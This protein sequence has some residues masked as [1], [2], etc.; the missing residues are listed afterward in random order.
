M[1]NAVANEGA[2]PLSR[3]GWSKDHTTWA[4]ALAGDI[5]HLRGRIARSNRGY[6]VVFTEDGPLVAASSSVRTGTDLNP[7]T[8]DFVLVSHPDDEPCLFAIAPRTAEL[9]RR[10]P[11]RQPLP[12]VLAANVDDVFVMHGLDR[13][14]NLRRLERQLV[15]AFDSGATPIVLL[16]K[17][18][19]VREPDE[20]VEAIRRI[21]PEAQVLAISARTGRGIDE[22]CARFAGS[23]SAALMGLSGI[24]K[25]TLVNALSGGEVQRTSEVRAADRRGRHTTVTRD[26]IVLPGGGIVIDT[27]G[28]RE[29]GL[30]KSYGGLARTFPEIARAA[31]ECRFANCSHNG[32]PDCAV[33]SA[34]TS[35]F[36]ERR[37][38]HYR[39]LVAELEQQEADLDEWAKRAESRHRAAAEDRRD[40]T[41]QAKRKRR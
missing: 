5:P 31:K 9:R 14:V 27:P 7:A 28:I 20:A 17:A 23:H 36:A 39:E 2:Y 12:Q 40:G 33:L 19:K 16:S 34:V 38:E 4:D 18:D 32:E 35:P 3:L 8:G 15:I 41:R 25:S 13:P 26:L 24:G 22:L 30:F 6:S 10:A 29:I 37:L 11:G 1:N 21:A